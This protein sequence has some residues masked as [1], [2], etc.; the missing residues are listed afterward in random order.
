MTTG[1]RCLTPNETERLFGRNGFRVVSNA[2]LGRIALTLDPAIVSKQTRVGGRPPSNVRHLPH[3]AEAMNRW[4]SSDTGRLLWIDYWSN[5]FPSIHEAFVSARIG[6]G[7][8]RS[9]SEAPGHYFDPR[10]YH[11]RDQT[12]ISPEQARL[13]GML[14][15]L[16]SLIMIDGWDGWLI[17]GESSDRIEFWEGNIYFYSSEASQ[18]TIANS[19]MDEFGCSRNPE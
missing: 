18:L 4:H 19:L 12:A 9:L 14:I 6:A 11:E 15:G 13:T 8:V 3:F 17:A 10:H 5:D 1:M 2:Q 16:M 7:E